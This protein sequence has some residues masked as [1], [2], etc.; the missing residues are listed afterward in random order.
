MELWVLEYELPDRSLYIKPDGQYSPLEM[1]ALKFQSLESAEAF[2]S[3]LKT[4][5]NLK[6]A[7]KKFDFQ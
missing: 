3:E 5:L 1:D 4:F 7:L 2:K 6:A